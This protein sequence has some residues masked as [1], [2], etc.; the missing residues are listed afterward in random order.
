L[1]LLEREVVLILVGI[2]INNEFQKIISTYTVNHKVIFTG[3]ISSHEV[4]NYYKL[5][6][7]H[8]LAS[9][10]EGLSQ[11]LLESMALEVPV[12]ATA[13]AGNLDLIQHGENGLLFKD[14]DILSL[15]N[16]INQLIED[17]DLR[18]KLI[19]AGKKT[20][21]EDFSIH[22]TIDNYETFFENLISENKG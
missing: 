8:I 7:I 10:S 13:A 2:D 15:A 3:N 9:T 21:Y 12:I 22:K 4:L 14:E 6:D 18:I 19:A 5:L 16:C 11:S 17:E 1:Q 20:A